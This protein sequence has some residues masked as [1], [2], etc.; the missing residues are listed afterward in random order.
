ML[1]SAEEAEDIDMNSSSR[2]R[3]GAVAR[4]QAEVTGVHSKEARTRI[5]SHLCCR[6]S[7]LIVSD[8]PTSLQKGL[9]LTM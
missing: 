3:F 5:A 7:F 2:G 4:M 9:L 6:L 1:L 8:M